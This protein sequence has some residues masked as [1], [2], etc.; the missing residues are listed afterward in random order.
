[1]VQVVEIG[2]WQFRRK[3]LEVASD[4]FSGFMRPFLEIEQ[5]IIPIEHGFARVIQYMEQ[6]MFYFVQ[7]I[8]SDED[9]FAERHFS[10]VDMFD[11]VTV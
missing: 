9:I 1:M 10:Y 8:E 7:Y 11:D 5:V 4:E 6:R 3:I 2:S